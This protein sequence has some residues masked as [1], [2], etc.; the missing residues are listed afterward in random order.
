MSLKENGPLPATET[1]PAAAMQADQEL[2]SRPTR[3]G[4]GLPL[5]ERK[6]YQNLARNTP[7]VQGLTFDHNQI[8]WISYWKNDQNKQV[9][10]HFPVS[11]FGFFGARLMALEERN[12]IQGWPLFADEAF[13][14]VEG[15]KVFAKS[16]PE[17]A[18]V[19]LQ[20]GELDPI[21]GEIH[22]NLYAEQVLESC[23]VTLEERIAASLATGL[24]A[25]PPQAEVAGRYQRRTATVT[26][27]QPA[28]VPSS[29]EDDDWSAQRKA[30]AGVATRRQRTARLRTA[31]RRNQIAP[32]TGE[33]RTTPAQVAEYETKER[34][35]APSMTRAEL[36]QESADTATLPYVDFL[37][38]ACALSTAALQEETVNQLQPVYCEEGLLP[39]QRNHCEAPEVPSE[40]AHMV[41][42]S[43]VFLGAGADSSGGS[44]LVS[45]ASTSCEEPEHLADSSV[46]VE[47][48]PDALRDLLNCNI[49]AP[50]ATGV[51]WD[52]E[53][54]NTATIVDVSRPTKNPILRHVR[55]Y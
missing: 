48:E 22:L 41:T 16:N 8:R 23:S 32:N 39:S 19:L 43:M 27:R 38:H 40:L 53:G 45:V 9:Q 52:A 15:L 33:R 51:D 12:R 55:P 1:L 42:A 10:K 28:P 30:M 50:T 31:A 17:C 2:K 44:R 5:H 18:A 37:T 11:R 4:R 14:L 21:T 47:H 7:R 49:S 46:F 20:G 35:A 24:R 36:P 29:H 54:S 6:V 34:E 13:H 3:I 26:N 25:L